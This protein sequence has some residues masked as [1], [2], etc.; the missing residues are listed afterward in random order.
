MEQSV[1]GGSK[2]EAV[3]L[4]K[5]GQIDEAI[6]VLEELCK[7]D[8]D[9]AQIQM[10]LGIAYGQKND[11]L[12]AIHHLETSCNLEDNPRASYNLATI[13]EAAH[14]IDEAVRNYRVA[15][16]LDPNYALAQEAL[17]K[18]QAQYEAAHVTDAPAADGPTGQVAPPVPGQQDFVPPTPVPPEGPPDFAEIQARRDQEVMEQQRRMM[19]AGLTYGLIC[20]TAF[21]TL[22][23]FAVS[24]YFLMLPRSFLTVFVVIIG[25]AIYGGL[26]GLW[27]GTTSG[28]DEAGMHAGAV[29]G[30]V[31]GLVMG[32]V[33]GAGVYAIIVMVLCAVV[34]GV[35]GLF[36]GRLVEASI[37][38]V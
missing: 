13:Y 16:Q 36:V 32:L 37:E 17:S 26:V 14:R 25:G 35:A 3:R 29:L 2:D 30:A 24:M 27:I 7:K 22:S 23:Y 10:Y 8:P 6:G 4:L 5:A 19:K 21:I 12:H 31:G 18:L 15:L 33:Y 38:Q 20:G 34:S 1:G 28:G 11:K 9:D